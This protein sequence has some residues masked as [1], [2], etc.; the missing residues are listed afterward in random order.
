LG[1]KDNRVTGWNPAKKAMIATPKL[2]GNRMARLKK[3]VAD[4]RREIELTLASPAVKVNDTDV[5]VRMRVL[6]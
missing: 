4:I 2:E 6:K 1:F 5:M 3:Q